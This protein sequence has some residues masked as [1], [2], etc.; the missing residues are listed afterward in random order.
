MGFGFANIGWYVTWLPYALV[1]IKQWAS[2]DCIMFVIKIWT[3]VGC[4]LL[5]YTVCL[6]DD[7]LCS[8]SSIAKWTCFTTN[9]CMSSI[10]IDDRKIDDS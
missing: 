3:A 8:A 7:F 6:F 4:I 1:D 5:C 9:S 10:C 2:P